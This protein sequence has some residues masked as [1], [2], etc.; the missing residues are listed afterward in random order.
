MTTAGTLNATTFLE[1]T[2]G[3]SH[4]SIDILPNVD[5]PDAFTKT[6]LGLSGIPLIFPND[7]PARPAPALP[8]T[9][10]ASPTPPILGTNNAPFQNFNTTK[11]LSVQPDQDLGQPHGQDRRLLPDQ[12]EAAE[13]LRRTPT[14]NIIFDNDTANPFDTGFAYANADHGR[15]QQYN[16]ASGYFIG[17]YSY[18]NIEWYLQDNWKASSKLTLDYGVRFYWISAAVRQRPADRELPPGAVRSGP[19]AAPLLPGP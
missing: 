7:G 17:K 2:W 11:D 6:N 9:A 3:Y 19:G 13:Q 16:Q 12:P 1:A 14:A 4:N 8:V 18:K 5:D 15:L 10:A